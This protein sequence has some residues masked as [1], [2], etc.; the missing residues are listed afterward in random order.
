MGVLRATS[1]KKMCG[2]F[3]YFKN[4]FFCFLLAHFVDR[5]FT[6]IRLIECKNIG[7]HKR[8]KRSRPQLSTSRANIETRTPWLVILIRMRTAILKISNI[9]NWTHIIERVFVIELI[10]ANNNYGFHISEAIGIRLDA[11]TLSIGWESSQPWAH[12]DSTS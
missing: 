4:N 2:V 6:A 3:S 5:S 10:V 11:T 8:Y 9:M 7:W 1:L 12:G